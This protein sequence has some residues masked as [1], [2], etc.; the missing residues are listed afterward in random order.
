[1]RHYQPIPSRRKTILISLMA[2]LMLVL[3]G[4]YYKLQVLDYEKHSDKA[5]A[6]SIRRIILTA[7]RG[8]IYD[9]FG[10]P[11][12][13]NRPTYNLMVIPVDV[14]DGFNYKLLEEAIRI[15]EN[16]LRHSI[17]TW[18]RTIG[19]FRPQLIKR[20]VK[21]EVMS[22]LEEHKL[23]LPGIMFSEMPARIYPGN[24]SLSHTLGYLRTV[25]DKIIEESPSL[26][27][28]PEDVYGAA[29]LEKVYEK[30]LRGKN[31]VE[32]HRVD[33][34]SRDHGV[35]R[36]SERFPPVPG[37][38]L[39]TTINTSLQELAESLME[40]KRGAAIAMDP[41]TGEILAFVSAPDYP[42]NSFIGPI[43]MDLWQSWNSDKDRPL[44]N[45]GINGLYPPGST[46]KLVAATL[47]LESGLI[48]PHFKVNCTGKYTLG[49]R[50]FHCWN[51]AGHGP[52]DLKNALKHSCNIYF[53][54]AIQGLDFQEWGEMAEAFG[55]GSRTGVDLPYESSGIIPTKEYLNE[56]Y[57]SRGWSTGNLLSFV[58][59][60]GDV[61]TTPLQSI[62]MMNLIATFGNTYQPHFNLYEEKVPVVMDIKRST[63][64]FIQNA[65]NEVVNS[66]DGTGRNAAIT[67][68]GIVRGKTGTSQNPHGDHHSSFAGYVIADT[69]EI[70]TVYV[71]V[72]NGG[73]GSGIAAE[74]AREL[75]QFF[76]DQCA[77]M[78]VH[79]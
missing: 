71:M 59:G 19:R 56:K 11:L 26:D 79:D 64:L 22:R 35:V 24:V 75:F 13:D 73:K 52:V 12:V 67:R 51:K 43:P 62:Q 23:E 5:N 1:M 53:Y 45:R 69:G 17:R 36:E 10:S 58:I 54:K 48:N 29:G 30:I 27:Y 3:A 39:Y 33:I 18:K 2:V 47:I 66:S 15:S 49:D 6:N 44:L 4:R 38:P 42:L 8:V 7:P 74:T 76:A 21:F 77:G 20:H 78:V 28:Q 34:Y 50:D 68:N 55:Y 61:L 32:F 41:V 37:N 31:G 72:E 70:M 40:G 65:L 9:R 60:Q 63:W 57:S 25:T 16:E 46:F 14:T